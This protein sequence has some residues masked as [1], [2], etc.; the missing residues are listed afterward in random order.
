VQGRWQAS[1]WVRNLT[2][3][4]YSTS[5]FRATDM[6]SRFA[7]RPRTFGATASFTY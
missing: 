3:Q 2:D 5:V 4:A 6:L 1:L 7:G